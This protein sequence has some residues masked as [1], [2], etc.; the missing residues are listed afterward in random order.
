MDM[1]QTGFCSMV[2][3]TYAA[4]NKQ[5]FI[6]TIG[7]YTMPLIPQVR[8]NTAKTILC[9]LV[10]IVHFPYRSLFVAQISKSNSPS[11]LCLIIFTLSMIKTSFFPKNELIVLN[12]IPVKI[13]GQKCFFDQSFFYFFIIHFQFLALV[14]RVSSRWKQQ[15]SS[16]TFSPTSG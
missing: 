2:F 8:T 1:H 3:H 9:T 11:T 14:S 7:K 13:P 4:V 12:S 15:Q 16:F 5:K 6:V 10:S